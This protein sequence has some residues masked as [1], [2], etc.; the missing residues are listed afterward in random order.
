MSRASIALVLVLI[1]ASLI[2]VV[3][4]VAALVYFGDR[5]IS[6]RPATDAEKRLVLTPAM[7]AGYGIASKD[8]QCQKLHTKRN[9]DGTLEVVL[10]HDCEKIFV[11]S[12]AEIAPTLKSARETYSAGIAVFRSTMAVLGKGAK[13]HPRPDLLT[14]GDEHY[15]AL[16]VNGEN[17]V[18]SIFVARQGRVVHSLV[19]TGIYFERPEEVAAVF[20]SLL[21]ESKK[22]YT[23]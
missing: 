13:L 22:Q 18:G 2:S 7:L 8:P 15:A 14:A 5:G 16:I 19:F 12:S 3:G 9:L 4:I 21:E 23:P 6:Q 11:S 20:A 1:V 10:E 17:T